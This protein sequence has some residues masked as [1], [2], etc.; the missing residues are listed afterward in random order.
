MRSQ[1]APPLKFDRHLTDPLGMPPTWKPS[2]DGDRVGGLLLHREVGQQAD[3]EVAS[4]IGGLS[5]PPAPDDDVAVLVGQFLADI[6][7]RHFGI[8]TVRDLARY[9]AFVEALHIVAAA[10]GGADLVPDPAP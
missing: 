5:A 6:L 10:D 7:S 8:W 9:T 3:D 2:D 4:D 1:P